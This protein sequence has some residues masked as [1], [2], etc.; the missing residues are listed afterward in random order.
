MFNFPMKYWS[1]RLSWDMA[2]AMA[3]A[4]AVATNASYI[5]INLVY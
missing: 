5:S 2:N 4:L 3:N 1:N